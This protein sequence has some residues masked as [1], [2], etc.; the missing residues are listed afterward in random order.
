ML[1]RPG[2]KDSR[3][4]TFLVKR[5]FRLRLEPSSRRWTCRPHSPQGALKRERSGK[6]LQILFITIAK[7]SNLFLL[8]RHQ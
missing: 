6:K 4:N 2:K 8:D 5:K 3:Q 1:T 7:H